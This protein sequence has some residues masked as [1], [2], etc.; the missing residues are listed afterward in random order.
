[1]SAVWSLHVLDA[2]HDVRSDHYPV[3]LLVACDDLHNVCAPSISSEPRIRYE[4][5]NA[6][7]F[8]ESL[9]A[10]LRSHFVPLIQQHVNVDKLADTLNDCLNSASHSTM[11]TTRKQHGA[12]ARRMEPWYDQACRD[13][14]KARDAVERN[15]HSIVAQK[16]TAEKQ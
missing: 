10:K 6:G 13:A 11:P 5:Q 3:Q 9:D 7:T 8:Q 2:A 15:L 12:P 1:M 4:S 16:E 14:C